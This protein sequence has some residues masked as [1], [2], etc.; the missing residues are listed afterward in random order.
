MGAEDQRDL[1]TVMDVVLGDVPDDETTITPLTRA[2]RPRRGS[3]ELG[4][5]VV[6]RP[7]AETRR[8]VSPRF[9]ESGAD[10]DGGSACR[11]RLLL[12]VR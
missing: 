1:A 12:G 6:Y 3:L 9:V 2:I 10:R 8:D 5:Q 11:D 4:R 7:S